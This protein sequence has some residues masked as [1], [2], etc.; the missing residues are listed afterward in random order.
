MSASNE[1]TI[2]HLEALAD[3]AEI[4][5]TAIRARYLRIIASYAR[6]V[7][8]K[9]ARSFKAQALE[10]S[11]EDGHWDSSYPPATEY[12]DFTGPRLIMIQQEKYDTVATSSGFYY[13]WRAAQTS[14]GLYV[15][16]D[17]AVWEC[18]IGGTGSVGRYAAHPGNCDVMIAL[19]Y[20]PA[21]LG[22]VLTSDLRAIEKHLRI[23]A[24]PL[25]LG[26]ALPKIAESEGEKKN[27]S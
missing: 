25:M 5:E 4:E 20:S 26:I 2:E 12:K 6:I 9:E 10:L 19:E 8:A 7:A 18:A 24:F 17:G 11:S 15:S 23:I 1:I 16:R 13:H 21:D 3:Q 22:Q 14:P 27:G